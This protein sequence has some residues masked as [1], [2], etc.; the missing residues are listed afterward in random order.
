MTQT[1]VLRSYLVFSDKEWE[2]VVILNNIIFY[3]SY[4][5]DYDVNTGFEIR[6]P[7]S[8]VISMWL[9]LKGLY[10]IL[11]EMSMFKNSR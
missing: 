7:A 2:L 4:N 8:G 1:I 11:I 3:I 6:S 9:N 10:G 5:I